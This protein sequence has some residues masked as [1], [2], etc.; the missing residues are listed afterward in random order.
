VQATPENIEVFNDAVK[1][2]TMQE[3]YADV[4]NAFTK[5]FEVLER[6]SSQTLYGRYPK[7]FKFLSMRCIKLAQKTP[8]VNISAF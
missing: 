7:D 2:T 5:A 3:G 6:V 4:K 8:G 1:A